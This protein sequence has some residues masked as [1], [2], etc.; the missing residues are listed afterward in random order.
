MGD[1]ISRMPNDKTTSSRGSMTIDDTASHIGLKGLELIAQED[2]VINVITGFDS[3]GEAY[4]FK[5]KKNMVTLKAGALHIAR[6]NYYFETIQLTSGSIII[7][8]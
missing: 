4:N 8:E 2:T 5:T 3:A 1:I 6:D 7:Y